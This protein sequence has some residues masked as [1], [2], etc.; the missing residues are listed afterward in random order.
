MSD[1]L[2]GR[3]VALAHVTVIDIA[4]GPARRNAT[5]VVR[6]GRVLAVDRPGEV[7]IAPPRMSTKETIKGTP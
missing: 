1:A 5:V 4:V 7:S 3:G 2:S 6:N